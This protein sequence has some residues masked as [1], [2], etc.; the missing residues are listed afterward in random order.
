MIKKAGSNATVIIILLK[1]NINAD[2]FRVWLNAPRKYK[3]EKVELTGFD[4]IE[5]KSKIV[6]C[7][8]DRESRKPYKLTLQKPQ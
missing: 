4:I 2:L 3:G 1:N 8:Y 6:I 7:A 5:T